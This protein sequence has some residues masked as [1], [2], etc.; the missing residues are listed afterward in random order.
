MNQKLYRIPANFAD[1]ARI[2]QADYRR[3]YAESI[4][5][6]AD[7]WGRVG[8]RLALSGRRGRALL[9]WLVGGPF[10][11][12]VAARDADTGALAPRASDRR[13]RPAE[14]GDHASGAAAGHTLPRP[15][16]LLGLCILGCALVRHWLMRLAF[17]G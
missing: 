5:D 11:L 14:V 3:M 12:G 15:M 4:E 13:G 6:P 17:R 7:F 16:G 8:R 10:R 9:R 1:G 2:N